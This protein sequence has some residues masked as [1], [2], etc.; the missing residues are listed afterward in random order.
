MITK[1]LVWLSLLLAFGASLEAQVEQGAFLLGGQ[2]NFSTEEKDDGIVFP[3]IGTSLSGEDLN[4]SS[5]GISPRLG[6][7]LSDQLVV[8]LS[9]NFQY[10]RAEGESNDVFSAATFPAELISRTYGGGLFARYYQNFG[11]MK[12]FGYW[13]GLQGSYLRTRSERTLD[14]V[15]FEVVTVIETDQLS[16][17]ITPGLYFFPCPALALE[18]SVGGMSYTTLEREGDGGTVNERRF[19]TF[20]SGQLGLRIGVSLFFGRSA[21]GEAGDDQA[22]PKED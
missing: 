9:G 14:Q 4:S 8:G 21:E 13:L 7:F 3:G 2:I 5:F 12:R 1:R 15:T 18:A 20:L 22:L 11:E 6:Y 16:F 19:S 10:G 17:G